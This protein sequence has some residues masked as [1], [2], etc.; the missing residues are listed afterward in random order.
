MRTYAILYDRPGP[1]RRSVSSRRLHG[2]FRVLSG[3]DEVSFPGRVF[4]GLLSVEYLGL[5]LL[6]SLK[7]VLPST[8]RATNS[9]AQRP[10]L[11]DLMS[12]RVMDDR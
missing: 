10:S 12:V 7:I 4:D 8:H 3:T 6:Y 2:P 1:T 5:L 11:S 9:C